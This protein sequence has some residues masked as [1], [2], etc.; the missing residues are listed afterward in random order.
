[1]ELFVV[2]QTKKEEEDTGEG[3]RS[4]STHITA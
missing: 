1:M 2:I 4:L 3:K